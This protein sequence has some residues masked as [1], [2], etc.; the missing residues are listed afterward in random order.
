M[1]TLAYQKFPEN[2]CFPSFMKTLVQLYFAS[3]ESDFDVSEL[4]YLPH[5]RKDVKA[6]G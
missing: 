6:F 2:P 3:E 1:F 4:R 5:L